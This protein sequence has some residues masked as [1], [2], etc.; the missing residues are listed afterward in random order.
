MY[1]ETLNYAVYDPSVCNVLSWWSWIAKTPLLSETQ[2]LHLGACPGSLSSLTCKVM[3]K[4]ELLQLQF[5]QASLGKQ[6]QYEN[7]RLRDKRQESPAST[8]IAKCLE[9]QRHLEDEI[10]TRK[11][12]LR[13]SRSGKKQVTSVASSEC[14]LQPEAQLQLELSQALERSEEA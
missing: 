5:G 13:R 1:C 6:L 10:Q 11:Q 9:E 2:V 8:E 14:G 4:R 3:W 7:V 12:L